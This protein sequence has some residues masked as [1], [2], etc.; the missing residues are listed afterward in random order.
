MYNDVDII[1]DKG[2]LREWRVEGVAA[3]EGLEGG[4]FRSW[5]CINPHRGESFGVVA[6]AV[7]APSTEVEYTN[8]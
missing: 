5:A 8:E 6:H 3:K 1:V 7:D 4:G 2:E